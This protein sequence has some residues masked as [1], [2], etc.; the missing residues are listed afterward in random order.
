MG[1][2]GV[3]GVGALE[4]RRT[5]VLRERD[6]ADAVQR[7]VT[8]SAWVIRPTTE[9]WLIVWPQAIG[10]GVSSKARSRKMPSRKASR[11]V[12]SIAFS[13]SAFVT[14]RDRRV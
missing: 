12:C 2:G 9:G 11:G 5:V 14:P 8:S 1:A 6:R 7:R 3:E 13:T 10:S 4:A